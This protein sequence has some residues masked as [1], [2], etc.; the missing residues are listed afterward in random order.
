[1]QNGS[2]RGTLLLENPRGSFVLDGAGL[3]RRAAALLGLS[4]PASVALSQSEGG[5]PL[6]AG[7]DVAAMAGQ[8]L[9]VGKR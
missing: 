9:Y 6:A 8:T 4:A 7:A 3:G 1:M 5:A 2:R